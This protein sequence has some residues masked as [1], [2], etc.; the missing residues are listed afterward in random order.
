MNESVETPAEREFQFQR[1]FFELVICQNILVNKRDEWLAEQIKAGYSKRNEYNLTVFM[2][3]DKNKGKGKKSEPSKKEVEFL[4]RTELESRNAK[5]ELLLEDQQ[6]ELSEQLKSFQKL[7]NN[8]KLLQSK[9]KKILPQSP[10]LKTEKSKP[11]QA[12]NKNLKQDLHK[13]FMEKDKLH[14]TTIKL[15]KQ[16]RKLEIKLGT[17]DKEL[18]LLHQEK[19]ELVQ[20]REKIILENQT[21]QQQ[22][23]ELRQELEVEK[24]ISFKTQIIPS[25]TPQINFF[26]TG[27]NKVNK[28]DLLQYSQAHEGRIQYLESE[29]ERTQMFLATLQI[30]K[31]GTVIQ[32][33]F[34]TID[35]QDLTTPP[36]FSSHEKSS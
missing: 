32:P 4:S 14:H 5:L 24:Q 20:H 35:S 10:Q 6:K 31:D 13:L 34:P 18:T 36:G 17:K 8:F 19:D 9:F 21:F 26:E 27:Q 33:V 16:V 30:L 23:Q 3:K 22:V 25:S 12:E 2:K 28:L 1:A 7:E 11:N 29:L 15:E